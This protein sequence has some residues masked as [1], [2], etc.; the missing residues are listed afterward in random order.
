MLWNL[1]AKINGGFSILKTV[2]KIWL[3]NKWNSEKEDVYLF[4]NWLREFYVGMHTDH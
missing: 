2:L 4:W 3:I 1:I